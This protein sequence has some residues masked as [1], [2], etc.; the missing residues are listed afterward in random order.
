MAL[1]QHQR[2]FERSRWRIG[3]WR[4]SGVAGNTKLMNSITVNDSSIPLPHSSSASVRVASVVMPAAAGI[5]SSRP[6]TVRAWP[7]RR[8]RSPSAAM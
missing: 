1:D 7:E 3:R 5:S 8:M 4:R 6:P 2:G